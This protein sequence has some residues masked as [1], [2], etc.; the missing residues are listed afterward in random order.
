MR[1]KSSDP[2]ENRSVYSKHRVKSCSWVRWSA[3]VLTISHKQRHCSAGTSVGSADA[4]ATV[5]VE[6]SAFTTGSKS[7][8]V[9][10]F[11]IET[12]SFLQLSRQSG[13]LV[14][15]GVN[16]ARATITTV[17][18]CFYP[19][20]IHVCLEAD[21]G[22]TLISPKGGIYREPVSKWLFSVIENDRNA[23][24][25]EVQSVFLPTHCNCALEIPQEISF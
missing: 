9:V 5:S 20:T 18:C 21:S 11:E 7:A 10:P 17:H 12:G 23:V 8:M 16:T 25:F 3:L 22:I 4:V 19:S 13:M 6:M 14:P 1:L 2:V 15:L 24:V